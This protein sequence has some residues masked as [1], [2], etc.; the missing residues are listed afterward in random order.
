[1]VLLQFDGTEPRPNTFIVSPLVSAQTNAIYPVH[2]IAHLCLH[3]V[4]RG[5]TQFCDGAMCD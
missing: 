2:I 4:A 5:N 1:M 3:G